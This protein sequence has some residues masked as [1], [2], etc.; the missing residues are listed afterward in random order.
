MKSL[1]R[2]VVIIGGEEWGW[3]PFAVFDARSA[4]DQTLQI[5]RCIDEKL[6]DRESDRRDY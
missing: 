4:C 3:Y 2:N 5:Y 1:L 6:S